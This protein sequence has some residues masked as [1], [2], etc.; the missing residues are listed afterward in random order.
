MNEEALN[1]SVRKFLKKLGVTAQREIEMAVRDA[2]AKGQLKGSDRCRRRRLSRLAALT[3]NLRSMATSS[4]RDVSRQ[5]TR[6]RRSAGRIGRISNRHRSRSGNLPLRPI[7]PTRH[8]AE[9][10][11]DMS[12]PRHTD[13]L[14]DRPREPDELRRLNLEQDSAGGTMWPWMVGILAAIIVA[15][16]VYDYERPILTTASTPPTSSSP[17]TTGAAPATPAKVNPLA[18]TPSAA[19]VTPAPAT[20][21]TPQ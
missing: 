8:N 17:T 19:P 16:L 3:S 21:P 18:A 6:R 5:C 20:Q 12:Y 14:T 4:W 15:M 11:S 9:W 1:T 2:A 7:V 13:P 10:R